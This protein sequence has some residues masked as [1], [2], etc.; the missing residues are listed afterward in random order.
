[1]YDKE[2]NR[3]RKLSSRDHLQN[4][5]KQFTFNEYS[6]HLEQTRTII[7]IIT[8]LFAFVIN[9]HFNLSAL[10]HKNYIENVQMLCVS[11]EY[12]TLVVSTTIYR[13][14]FLTWLY[15]TDVRY[16]YS[17]NSTTY[18]YILSSKVFYLL[19]NYVLLTSNQCSLSEIEISTLLKRCIISVATQ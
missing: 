5:K 7:W 19:S 9:M 3:F 12:S 6:S 11:V 1:M 8:S 2:Y 18:R 4:K 15:R 16:N 14:S 17:E 13:K 10:S